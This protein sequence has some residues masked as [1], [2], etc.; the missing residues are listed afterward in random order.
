[1]MGKYRARRGGDPQQGGQKRASGRRQVFLRDPKFSKN[2]PRTWVRKLKCW[3]CL[4]QRA[5]ETETG[6]GKLR[7]LPLRCGTHSR[8][9]RHDCGG[10][11]VPEARS[12]PLITVINK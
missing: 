4:L 12:L 3:V 10:R 6:L 9:T 1:M 8:P 2:S 11:A 7:S 5:T